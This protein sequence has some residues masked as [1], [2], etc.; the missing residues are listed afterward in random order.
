MLI[1]GIVLFWALFVVGSCLDSLTGGILEL[2]NSPRADPWL[3]GNGRRRSIPQSEQEPVRLNKNKLF[4]EVVINDP[5]NQSAGIYIRVSQRGAAYLTNLVSEGLPEL[6]TNIVLPRIDTG[7]FKGQNFVVVQFDKPTVNATFLNGTGVSLTISAPYVEVQGDCE[8]DILFSVSSH[9]LAKMQNWT[10]NMDISL[11]RDVGDTRNNITVTKCEGHVPVDLQFFG[12][13]SATLNSF[14]TLIGE[15]VEAAVKEKICL[16]PGM[17]NA[18]LEQQQEEILSEQFWNQTREAEATGTVSPKIEDHLCSDLFGPVDE[19]ITKASTE[20]FVEEQ[21]AVKGFG[22]QL[23]DIGVWAPDLTMRFPP[24]FS[25]KDVIFGIDGGIVLNGQTAKIDRPKFAN[26]TVVRDQMAGLIVSEYVPN[27]FLYHVFD[28][29]LGTFVESFNL[30]HVPPS[31]RPFARVVCSDCMVILK[32][33]LTER[34]HITIDNNGIVLILEGDVGAHFYR[35]NK[36][37]ELLSADGVIRV[38]LKPTFRNSR[39][40]SDVELTGVDFKVYKVGLNGVF[41]RAARKLLNFIIPKTIWPRVQKSLRFAINRRGI[42]LPTV[43]G[44][45]FEKLHVDY[46]RHAAILSADFSIDLQFFLNSFKQFIIAD[47]RGNEK[48]EQYYKKFRYLR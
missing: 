12:G 25:D 31:L 11:Q 32:A 21:N 6:L 48:L 5:R 28:K 20:D 7:T 4:E 43:C 45:Q 8:V 47:L 16:L 17:L 23:S 24:T 36:T 14:R 33:N 46:I 26:V 1:R 2:D 39:I 19:D 18:F 40:Y 30:R 13:D 22:T 27:A 37:H 35:K 41:A 15:E 3:P 34:P 44:I 38:V 10:V 29:S 42:K 9:M